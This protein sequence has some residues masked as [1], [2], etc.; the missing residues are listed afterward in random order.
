[1]TSMET[2]DVIHPPYRSQTAL[3]TS[4]TSEA[5]LR[6]SFQQTQGATSRE[7]DE[8]T[9]RSQHVSSTVQ[10]TVHVWTEVRM[11]WRINTMV[12]DPLVQ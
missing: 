12:T 1:M 11:Q 10:Y 4:K 3:C 2:S 5:Q 9:R 8:R 6:A 7:L